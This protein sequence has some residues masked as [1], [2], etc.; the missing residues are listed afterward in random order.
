VTEAEALEI[1]RKAGIE[2]ASH[3]LQRLKSAQIGFAEAIRRRAT[4]EP[5]SQIL[6]TRAFWK[7]EFHVT[8]DVLDPRPD[9][10]TLVEAALSGRFSR[11]LDLGTGSGCILLSLLAERENTQGVG[12]DL[13]GRALVVALKNAKRLGLS[14][15]VDLIQSNWFRALSGRF[16]LIV[17]N[18]PYITAEA[19]ETLHQSV[20]E[21]EPKLALT[22][23]GDGLEPYR[24][25]ARDAPG[26][27]TPDARLIVEIGYDQ[28][29][30]VTEIFAQAGFVEI[31]CLKDLN[32]KPRVICAKLAQSG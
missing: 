14:D 8:S 32:A 12:A 6:G 1:L 24:I 10:E 18:P 11:V 27:M 30:A 2:D 19:Y 17:S 7:H 29:A 3:G 26:H 28:D 9:T 13:S 20:R 21:F 31:T 16:D 25:I 15:R 5:V 4:G 22:P 23:G